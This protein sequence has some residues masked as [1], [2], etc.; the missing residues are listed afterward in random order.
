[1]PTIHEP[2]LLQEI[3]TQLNPQPGQNFIDCTF[4]GGG[5]SLELLERILP[6]RNATPNVAGGPDGKIAGIDWDKNT[7]QQSSNKNLILVNDN[8]RN[9]KS[10]FERLKKEN[11]MGE[12]SGI[13][14]DLGLSSDQ[15]SD[16]ERGFSFD[17]TGPL[18]MRFDT[19]SNGQTAADILNDSSEQE[20]V[21]IFEEYG[22][23]PFA[24]I[25]AKEIIKERNAGSD[26]QSAEMLV[27][28]I[29]EIYR[30][31]FRQPSR[32]NPATRV[33]QALRIAVNDEFGNI[34]ITLP[35][36]IDVL[37]PGGRLA[38]IS[39]HS[40]EDRII[41][42]FFRD[43]AKIDHSRIKLITKKPIEA[44]DE[45]I[46]SNPRSRSAKLRVIEKI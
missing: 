18:D 39:F 31:K 34:R 41:K 2:V 45:E 7:I 16:E 32:R 21:R 22:E 20:L 44:T 14:L 37:R 13:L 42:N 33:F 43:M 26:V 28:L 38:V 25:I 27:Q 5:H 11:S 30:R 8:Y 36:A 46:K 17:S 29:G 24:K 10:I 19:D 9:L 4:G 12:I 1:M 35:Q 40:G 6:A 15:L 3:L 23:E